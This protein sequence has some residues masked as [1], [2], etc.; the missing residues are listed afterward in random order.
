MTGEELHIEAIGK[1]AV[2]LEKMRIRVPGVIGKP[3]IAEA[4]AV[5]WK[6]PKTIQ[7]KQKLYKLDKVSHIV[8]HSLGFLRKANHQNLELVTEWICS[9]SVEALY[10]AM[11]R[12][13][14]KTIALQGIEN[15]SLYLW[16]ER[17]LPVSMVQKA[18]PTQEGIAVNLVFTPPNHRR[19][20]YALSCV[21]AFSQALLDT[22][23]AFCCLFADADNPT[24]NKLYQ[25]IGYQPIAE[26]VV[27]RFTDKV[28]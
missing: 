24:S 23:I 8:K 6:S 16:E 4:F 1:L 19:K 26:V 18:R 11:E 17:G 25:K 28:I 14:A 22:G 20:G 7:M 27:Y 13:Q 3:P 12:N 2:Y 5:A 10:E 21:A 15:S 9:F